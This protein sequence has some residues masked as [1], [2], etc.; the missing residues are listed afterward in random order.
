MNNKRNKRGRGNINHSLKQLIKLG[1]SKKWVRLLVFEVS[2]LLVGVI[3]GLIIEENRVHAN[4]IVSVHVSGESMMPT[5]NDGEWIHIDKSQEAKANLAAGDVIVFYQKKI[6]AYLIKR[7]IGMPG[8]I[9]VIAGNQ[10]SVNQHVIEENYLFE[11]D[12]NAE[13]TPGRLYIVPEDCVF[14]LGDNRN[15]SSDS[16]GWMGFVSLESQY[17]GAMIH[18]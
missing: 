17:V 3:A 15:N 1:Q 9:V 6:D 13:Q 5:L 16:R 11:S 14:V 18:D 12:W 7:V 8:D 4:A 2:A 10:I